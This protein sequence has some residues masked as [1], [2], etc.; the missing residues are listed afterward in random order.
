MG[1]ELAMRLREGTK[2]AHVTAER[3][4]I[5]RDLLRGRVQRAP[6]A[7]LLRSLREVYAALEEGMMRRADHPVIG[8][9][10]FPEL[11]RLPSLE[12]DLS[13]LHGPLWR[14]ELPVRPAAMQLAERIVRVTG[15]FPELLVAHAYVRY[16]GDLSGGQILGRIVRQGLGLGPAGPPGDAGTAFYEFDGVDVEATKGRYRA[17]LASLVLDEETMDALVQEAVAS[18]ALQS[19]LF[20]QI[21]ASGPS[22]TPEA[23]SRDE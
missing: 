19:S 18:F 21:A 3:S 14:R 13:A 5:M 4:G 11:V 15:H 6:Y 22:A 12:A 8:R 23:H 20:E 7:L 17:A 16:L 10:Y 9:I 2:L 1:S